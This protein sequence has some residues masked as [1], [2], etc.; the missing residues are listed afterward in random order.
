VNRL[1]SGSQVPRRRSARLAQMA[2]QLYIEEN[3]DDAR[4]RFDDSDEYRPDVDDT[5]TEESPERSPNAIHVSPNPPRHSGNPSPQRSRATRRADVATATNA[6]VSRPTPNANVPKPRTVSSLSLRQFVTVQA[7][8]F[9]RHWNAASLSMLVHCVRRECMQSW[10]IL[11]SGQP[12]R[13][14]VMGAHPSHPCTPWHFMPADLRIEALGQRSH[15]LV[16]TRWIPRLLWM[17]QT[18]HLHLR[19][20]SPMTYFMIHLLSNY[21]ALQYNVARRIEGQTPITVGKSGT[22]WPVE[23]RS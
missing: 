7:L 14:L 18:A 15:I 5:T 11:L 8:E 6:P 2:P 21:L 16:E 9:F 23:S 4:D 13:V 1:S 3:Y 10:Y 12:R 22:V 20:Y 19:R 17:R